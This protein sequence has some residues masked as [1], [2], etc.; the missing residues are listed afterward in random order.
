MNLNIFSFEIIDFAAYRAWQS[1]SAICKSI[2]NSYL[3]GNVDLT[4]PE[5]TCNLIQKKHFGPSW[6]GISKELYICIDGGKSQ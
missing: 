4:K 1:S 3:L 2:H 5:Q 6:L